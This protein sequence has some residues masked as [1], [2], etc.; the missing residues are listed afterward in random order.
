[1]SSLQA[2]DT[3][4]L[5][6]P[7]NTQNI[8]IQHALYRCITLGSNAETIPPLSGHVR[9]RMAWYLALA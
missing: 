6:G 3:T 1:M 9:G 5:D 2:P 8:Q 4:E 7:Q